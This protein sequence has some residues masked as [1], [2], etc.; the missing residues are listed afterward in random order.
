MTSQMGPLHF[1]NRQHCPA[2]VCLERF[3]HVR[4]REAIAMGRRKLGLSFK[5]YLAAHI[6]CCDYP[7]DAD[8]V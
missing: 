7:S 5:V 6:V 4:R 8:F 1:I 2:N 3:A